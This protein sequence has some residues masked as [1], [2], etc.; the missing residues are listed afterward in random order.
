LA[1]TLL[2]SKA[3]WEDWFFKACFTAAKWLSNWETG[4][5]EALIS[6][7]RSWSIDSSASLRRSASLTW[8]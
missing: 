5:K 8:S 1:V 2:C 6:A 4:Y 7:G 3:G